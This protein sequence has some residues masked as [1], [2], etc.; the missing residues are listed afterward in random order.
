MHQTFF[1]LGSN[2]IEL[3]FRFDTRSGV[4]SLLIGGQRIEIKSN[5]FLAHRRLLAYN[6]RHPRIA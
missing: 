1:H 2:L 5:M 6:K 4:Q 3:I